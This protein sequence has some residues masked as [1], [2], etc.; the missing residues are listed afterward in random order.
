MSCD[1]EPS[2]SLGPHIVGRA[3]TLLDDGWDMLIAHPPCTYLAL[4]GVRWL[5]ERPERWDEMQQAALLFRRFLDA[6]IPRIAVVNPIMHR[7][8]VE[9]AGIGPPTCKVQPWQFGHPETKETWFWLRGLQPLSP[10]CVVRG[11]VAKVHL[12]PPSPDRGY[13]RSLTPQGMAEAIADQWGDTAAQT[14]F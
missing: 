14:L 12:S 3:E 1:I 8:A 7:H 10:T 4:S 13:Q 11:R 5:H 6:A 2:D 9:A